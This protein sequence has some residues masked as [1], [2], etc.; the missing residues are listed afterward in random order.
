MTCMRKFA[1]LLRCTILLRTRTCNMHACM[2][3]VCVHVYVCVCVCVCLCA[4]TF[5]VACADVFVCL[6]VHIWLRMPM[7]MHVDMGVCVAVYVRMCT[8]A[9]VHM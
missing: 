2:Y 6:F 5:G 1:R 9:C 4:C 7:C 8:N 3:F